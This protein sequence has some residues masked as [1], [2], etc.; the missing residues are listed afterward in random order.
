MRIPGEPLQAGKS[1]VG[2]RDMLWRSLSAMEEKNLGKG[3]AM[4]Q[5]ARPEEVPKDHVCE[6]SRRN[7]MEGSLD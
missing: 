3:T 7:A 5:P 6:A 1:E 4:A 2:A